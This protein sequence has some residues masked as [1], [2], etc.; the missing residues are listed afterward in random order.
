MLNKTIC[1]TVCA[2]GFN[3]TTKILVSF[4]EH[5]PWRLA[6]LWPLQPFTLTRPKVCSRRAR[7]TKRVTFV[8]KIHKEENPTNK[9]SKRALMAGQRW[10]STFMGVAWEWQDAIGG[11]CQVPRRW[12]AAWWHRWAWHLSDLSHFKNMAFG[13]QARPSCACHQPAAGAFNARLCHYGSHKPGKD[14]ACCDSRP[15]CGQ[16][17]G[18]PLWHGCLQ[19][20]T[21][22]RRRVD[23]QAFSLVAVSEGCS[24]RSPTVAP[25]SA[26]WRD[27]LG[28]IP[29]Q[30]HAGR[31][32]Q[33]VPTSSPHGCFCLQGMGQNSEQP[34]RHLPAVH[35]QWRR[36]QDQAQAQQQRR[37]IYLLRLR[38]AEN[39]ACFSP[40]ATCPRRCRCEKGVPGLPPAG[41]K[42]EM[43]Q[44]QPHQAHRRV[45]RRDG[46]HAERLRGVQD[47]PGWKCW[48][49][50]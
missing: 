32:L 30:H 25:P 6:C 31:Q 16:A 19:P 17:H 8:A 46:H 44:V 21:Q 45:P 23:P 49:S 9:R 37:Q 10:P 2:G 26:G 18:Q 47:L 41:S 12:M 3:T 22:Q 14:A 20:S 5:Y 34:V 1:L 11:L 48:K 13:P 42:I 4:P 43:R 29:G 7:R 24:R 35:P 33:E 15:Q 39:G 36:G 38:G 27:W 50:I 28:H 40:G